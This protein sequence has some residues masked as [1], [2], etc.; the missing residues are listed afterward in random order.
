MREKMTGLDKIK[1]N[2]L[3]EAAEAAKASMD[4]AKAKASQIEEQNKADAEKKCAEISQKNEAQLVQI[5][6]RAKSSMELER[7]RKMLE[8]KQSLI[9]EVIDNAKTQIR[10]LPDEEYFALLLK[11]ADKAIH[12][13]EGIISLSSKDLARMPKDFEDKIKAIAEDRQANM[14]VS[15]DAIDVED[16]F[17]LSY[18]GIEENCTLEAIFADKK[19]ELS[20]LVQKLLF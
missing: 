12:E 8:T 9:A 5:K 6:E 10:E 20:D 19:E 3:D 1:Q 14:S 18:G 4:E 16:G 2:I 11:I 17:V 13:G 15:K 7:S